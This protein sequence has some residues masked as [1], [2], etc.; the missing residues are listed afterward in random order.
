MKEQHLIFSLDL[1][2]VSVQRLRDFHASPEAIRILTPPGTLHHLTGDLGP[3]H[4]GQTLTLYVKKMGLT[5]PWRAR[6]ESVSPQGFTDRMI[7]GPFARWRHHHHFVDLG[8]Y[9]CQ[10][11]DELYF[12]LPLAP[13]SDPALPWVRLDLRKLFR[14]RHQATRRALQPN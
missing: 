3:L 11:L 8:S 13:L 10:L 9:G 1:P 6:N 4:E 5:L 14:F 12:Q 2:G 7:S